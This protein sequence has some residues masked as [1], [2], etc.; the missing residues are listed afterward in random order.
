MAAGAYARHAARFFGGAERHTRHAMRDAADGRSGFAVAHRRRPAQPG[1]DSRRQQRSRARAI[2][3]TL[4]GCRRKMG[5]R[6]GLSGADRGAI[7]HR[8]RLRGL[9]PRLSLTR[10]RD[11][12][13]VGAGTWAGW[14][15]DNIRRRF[16]FFPGPLATDCAQIQ[17]SLVS[18]LPAKPLRRARSP[19]PVPFRPPFQRAILFPSLSWIR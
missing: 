11:D 13:P 5:C 3:A 10:T 18:F 4:P 7:G 19:M 15:A 9:S 12:P 2:R 6:C 1:A 8:R 16:S 14:I 17:N